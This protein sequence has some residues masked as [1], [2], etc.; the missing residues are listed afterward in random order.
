MLQAPRGQAPHLFA[1]LC[2][3][4]HQSGSAP[5]R[6]DGETPAHYEHSCMRRHEA[7]ISWMGH[8]GEVT[9][10]K[11]RRGRNNISPRIKSQGKVRCGLGKPHRTVTVWK[12]VAPHREQPW[13]G[14]YRKTAPQKTVAKVLSKNRTAPWLI[15]L[16]YFFINNE[17]TVF[18]RCTAPHRDFSRNKKPHREK[19]RP[20]FPR[21]IIPHR[22]VTFQTKKRFH[23]VPFPGKSG[24]FVALSH[25]K[26]VSSIQHSGHE[27]GA[28]SEPLSG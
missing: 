28:K 25:G 15:W 3:I 20:R 6:A 10:Y 8:N 7:F 2:R 11:R 18:S 5:K 14:F 1:F 21:E 9:R 17:S 27:P 26:N 23:T 22:T 24:A 13:P 16:I 12:C 4:V 19:P